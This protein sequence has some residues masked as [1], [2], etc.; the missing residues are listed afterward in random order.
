MTQVG[1][2]RFCFTYRRVAVMHVH[3]ARRLPLH[4]AP[5]GLLP[6]QAAAV[7]LW[8]T[9]PP[10]RPLSPP[11]TAARLALRAGPAGRTWDRPFTSRAA[12]ARSAPLWPNRRIIAGFRAPLRW[13]P[14]VGTAAGGGPVPPVTRCRCRADGRRADGRG[15]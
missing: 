9:R 1:V 8:S 15:A 10:G 13:R 14:P 12:P 4:P 3:I 11:V 7:C 5:R 2:H 6:R